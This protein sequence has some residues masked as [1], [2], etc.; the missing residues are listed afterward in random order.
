MRKLW[1]TLI[2]TILLLTCSVTC[3]TCSITNA[4]TFNATTGVGSCTDAE[5]GWTDNGTTFVCEEQENYA[6]LV[7][8]TDPL[9]VVY[10]VSQPA[11][12][13]SNAGVKARRTTTGYNFL[14]RTPAEF[15]A[16]SNLKVNDPFAFKFNGQL[17]VG[18]VVSA[19]YTG[20]SVHVFAFHGARG[21]TKVL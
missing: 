18:K 13:R 6:V 4:A 3:L 20:T 2:C 21:Y 8:Y 17:V 16:D 5:V 10:M 19:T 11:I 15:I 14:S 7:Q 1:N 9:G 12:R